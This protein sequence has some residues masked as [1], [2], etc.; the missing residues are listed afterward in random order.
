MQLVIMCQIEKAA[1]D[2][3]TDLAV[4][5]S[6][7]PHPKANARRRHREGKQIHTMFLVV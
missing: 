2:K 5:P 6:P 4:D 3:K 7:T 1:S